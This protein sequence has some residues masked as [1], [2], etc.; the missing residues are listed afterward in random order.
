MIAPPERSLKDATSPGGAVS[1]FGRL[2]RR[3]RNK[4]WTYIM[5]TVIFLERQSSGIM[6]WHESPDAT[7]SDVVV[8]VVRVVPVAVSTPGVVLIVVPR[9]PPEHLWLQPSEKPRF[10]VSLILIDTYLHALHGR[11]SFECFG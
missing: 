6:K 3:R 1:C 8:P 5:H 9:A 4:A 11:S 2:Q 7:K 10:A